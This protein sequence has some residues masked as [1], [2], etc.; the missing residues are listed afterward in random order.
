MNNKQLLALVIIIVAIALI[1]KAPQID[2]PK[3]TFSL[4]SNKQPSAELALPPISLEQNGI[5]KV[6]NFPTQ[7]I[8]STKEPFQFFATVADPQG[9]GDWCYDSSCSCQCSGSY[10]FCNDWLNKKS[11]CANKE[12]MTKC[13][14]GYVDV[15]NKKCCPSNYPYLCDKNSLCYKIPDCDAGFVGETICKSQ[16][17]GTGSLL[18]QNM[19]KTC[20][21][22]SQCVFGGNDGAG[23]CPSQYVQSGN[24]NYCYCNY[25]VWEGSPYRGTLRQQLAFDTPDCN[26]C[27]N[28]LCSRNDRCSLGQILCSDSSSFVSCQTI[29]DKY[30]SKPFNDWS[31]T[32][33]LCPSNTVCNVNKCESDLDNDGFPDSLDQCPNKGEVGKINQFGCPLIC[34]ENEVKLADGTCKVLTQTCIDNNLNNLCDQ[35]DPIVWADPINNVPICADRNG[36]KVCDGIESLFCKDSNSNKICDSDEAKWIATHCLDENG[37]GVC[38]GIE[39]DKTVCDKAFNPVCDPSTNI[40]YPSQCFA[41]AFNAVTINGACKVQPTIIRLD[42]ATGSVP[43]PSGYICDFETGWLFKRDTIY[44]NITIDCRNSGTL[45]GFTCSQVGESWVWTRTQLVNIDCYSRGCPNSNQ[46]CQGGVCVESAKRCPIDIDC[47]TLGSNVVC[48]E[49]IGLCTKVQYI[50]TTIEDGETTT[51]TPKFS[52]KDIPTPVLIIGFIIFLM[53]VAR[54]I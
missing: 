38:D 53:L 24:S 17:D 28:N 30:F 47:S 13:D 26:S 41:N 35:D 2:F 22:C 16:S 7:S 9:S 48:D 36:D 6:D 32:K 15:G 27:A 39:N 4:I 25:P 11:P 3:N 50:P 14:S 52:F 44:Q 46:L 34:K 45:E 40:T 5:V 18:S 19:D 33:N 8:F 49:E 31:K 54:L 21:P 1:S 42:C 10:S 12:E 20:A 23:S 51:E 43:I 29:T 37:N